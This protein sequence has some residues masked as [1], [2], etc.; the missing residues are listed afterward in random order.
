MHGVSNILWTSDIISD[1]EWTSLHITSI[2]TQILRK[3]IILFRNGYRSSEQNAVLQNIWMFIDR[4]GWSTPAPGTQSPLLG[5]FLVFF[6]SVSLYWLYGIRELTSATPRTSSRITSGPVWWCSDLRPTG[7][8][9][10]KNKSANRP[11][12]MALQGQ[13]PVRKC[14]S[15][16]VVCNNIYN[17]CCM[18]FRWAPRMTSQGL[19]T[20]SPS[21]IWGLS[22]GTTIH[23]DL[24]ESF[25]SSS[26][27][28]P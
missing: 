8:P 3:K 24:R 16:N 27:F 15:R 6:I 12:P 2:D 14:V 21:H 4:S 5:A 10:T 18:Y 28:P 22:A 19:G 25:T 1:F 20:W 23:Q 13:K 26:S 9:F 11:C 7:E 17:L